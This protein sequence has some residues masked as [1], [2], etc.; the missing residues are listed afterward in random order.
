M[1]TQREL[2][3]RIQ[4]VSAQLWE[5]EKDLIAAHQELQ[6]SKAER[7]ALYAERGQMEPSDIE[8]YKIKSAAIEEIDGAI[9]SHRQNLEIASQNQFEVYRELGELLETQRL[10]LGRS[11]PDTPLS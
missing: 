9:E 5:M 4:R 3:D 7:A 8:E 1:L 11:E 10:L 2:Q 6:A